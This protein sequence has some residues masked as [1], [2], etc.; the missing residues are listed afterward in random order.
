ML[1]YDTGISSGVGET[2]ERKKLCLFGQ[3]LQV[4]EEYHIQNNMGRGS[5]LQLTALMGDAT[6]FF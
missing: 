2:A 4:N 3:D 6:V 5:Y 1:V